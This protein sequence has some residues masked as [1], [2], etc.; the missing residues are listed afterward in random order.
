MTQVHGKDNV[1][2]R[3][4]VYRWIQDIKMEVLSCRKERQQVAPKLSEPQP[5]LI[6]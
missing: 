6:E 2:S 3:S 1:P 5:S 4:T